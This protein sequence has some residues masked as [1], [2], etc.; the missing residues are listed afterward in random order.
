MKL[1]HGDCLEIMKTLKDKS[2]D[3]IFCDLPYG[4]TKNKWDVVIPFEPLWEQYERLIKDNGAIILTA[5]QP[6][7]SQLVMSNSKMF[8]YEMIWEKPIASNQLNVNNQPLRNHESILIFYKKQPVYN[9]QKTSG[10]PY[11][12]S[13]NGGYKNSSYDPQSPTIKNNDGYRHAKSVLKISNP[14]IK[15]G[16]PTQKPLELL[17]NLISAY[18]NEGDTVLD[19]CMGSGSTGAACYELNREFIGIE[20][21]D[22]YFKMASTLLTLNSLCCIIKL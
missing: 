17:K 7:S 21:D 14:R 4:V 8:R 20:K 11:S 3:M 2:I 22:K 16:H 10:L 15:D 1:Y 9:E 12:V 19:N 13:R 5:T 18:S 6:F